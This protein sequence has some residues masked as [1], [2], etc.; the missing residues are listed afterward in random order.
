MWPRM[1]LISRLLH[2]LCMSLNP[3]VLP[4]G[5]GRGEDCSSQ[6]FERTQPLVM[7]N[8]RML[9]GCGSKLV[10]SSLH[11]RSKEEDGLVAGGG[12]MSLWRFTH[13]IG[14]S[15]LSGL[16][17]LKVL[18]PPENNTT[19][20]K[21]SI[22][23]HESVGTFHIHGDLAKAFSRF[24]SRGCRPFSLKN[25][26]L[27]CVLFIYFC[28]VLGQEHHLISFTYNNHFIHVELHGR[29]L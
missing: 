20:W 11:S 22:P 25:L 4:M 2:Y 7:G 18:Q 9:F 1:K 27:W 3:D 6:S 29:D 26:H 14:S 8:A 5:L 13:S 19:Y 16:C 15:L 24:F 28:F 17:F 21:A 10:T 23:T 12:R